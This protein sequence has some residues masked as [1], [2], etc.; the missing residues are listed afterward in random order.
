MWPIWPCPSL[1]R[2]R[3]Q[4]GGEVTTRWTDSSFTNERSRPSP[5]TRQW[6]V[7]MSWTVVRMLRVSERGKLARKGA[8]KDVETQV[9]SRLLVL[10][11]FASGLRRKNEGR[12]RVMPFAH[13]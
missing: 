13:Q 12:R 9:Q 2:L 4:Y 1:Y 10:A 6:K 7:C 11:L 3:F 8:D 5:L